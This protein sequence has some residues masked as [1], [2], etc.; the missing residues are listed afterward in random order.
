MPGSLHGS[1]GQ[2]L[3][4]HH[5]ISFLQRVWRER[6]SQSTTRKLALVVSNL[7]LNEHRLRAMR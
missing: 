6:F 3:P 5:S 4:V 2:V 1:E 7:H